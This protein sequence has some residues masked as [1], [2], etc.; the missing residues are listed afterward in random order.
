MIDLSHVIFE[1]RLNV[2]DC[3]MKIVFDGSFLTTFLTWSSLKE[4]FE[5]LPEDSSGCA[6]NNQLISS[7]QPSRGN[8]NPS[9]LPA[10]KRRNLLLFLVPPAR[11]ALQVLPALP[12]LPLSC[13][14]AQWPCRWRNW[15]S[16]SW[17]TFHSSH[18]S[19]WNFWQCPATAAATPTAAA[20]VRMIPV[21]SAIP[22]C[23]CCC[24]SSGCCSCVFTR[25]MK[26]SRHQS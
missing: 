2:I 9:N 15:C 25:R 26:T 7:F 23:T 14:R 22:V 19:S 12:A 11:P 6:L 3:F 1:K 4:I 5:A 20:A 10:K 8:W 21:Q 13:S 24:S 18:C 17:R 16:S